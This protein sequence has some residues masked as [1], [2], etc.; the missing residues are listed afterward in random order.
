LGS[1]AFCAKATKA[2]RAIRYSPEF[3]G[4]AASIPAAGY[5]FL[6]PFRTFTNAVF[7]SQYFNHCSAS[8]I[9]FSFASLNPSIKK[10]PNFPKRGFKIINLKTFNKG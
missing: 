4:A 1:Q 10:T 9:P 6:N 8:T 5:H 3:S 7:G 2:C